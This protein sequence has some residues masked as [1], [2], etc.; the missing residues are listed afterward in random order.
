MDSKFC[1]LCQGYT[2]DLFTI[3]EC[4]FVPLQGIPSG[5]SSSASCALERLVFSVNVIMPFQILI[6]KFYHE[7]AQTLA[8]TYHIEKAFPLTF[9]SGYFGADPD[10]SFFETL[11]Y[12]LESHTGIFCL[13]YYS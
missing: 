13:D 7:I 11:C 9:P 8:G 2:M 1:I 4:F 5:E 12:N 6:N 3:D 10:Y